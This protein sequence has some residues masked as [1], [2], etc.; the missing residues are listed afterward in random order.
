MSR[1]ASVR[2]P[3]PEHRAGFDRDYDVFLLMHQHRRA[4]DQLSGI[5]A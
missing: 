4:I 1:H 3:N 2:E 5:Q